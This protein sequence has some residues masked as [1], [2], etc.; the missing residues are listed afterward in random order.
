MFVGVI[1]PREQVEQERVQEAVNRF[2][3][4][5][6]F[7]LLGMM[8]PWAEWGQLGWPLIVA[9]VGVLA[10]RRVP[11]IFIVRAALGPLKGV[12]EASFAG[13]FG[14][15]GIA[16]LFYA[17][18]SERHTGLPVTWAVPAA[19]IVGSVL[20]HGFTASSLTRWFGAS[21]KA[22]NARGGETDTGADAA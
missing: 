6:I 20:V 3:I 18:F 16:A 12:R 2:F 5:P 8:L 9:V 11:A 21:V 17:C 10:L 7:A 1:R 13:W 4:I 22:D 15:I 19:V 14:P